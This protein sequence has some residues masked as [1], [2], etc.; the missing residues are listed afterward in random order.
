MH[1]ATAYWFIAERNTVTEE[2]IRTFPSSDIFSDRVSFAKPD[3]ER[4]TS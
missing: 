4:G 2:I 1:V 3:E